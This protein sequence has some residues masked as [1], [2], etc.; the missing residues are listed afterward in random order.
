[1]NSEPRKQPKVFN[2]ANIAFVLVVCASYTSV[3]AALIY[4]RRSL[5]AWEVGVFVAAVQTQYLSSLTGQ[6]YAIRPSSA[7][8]SR[9]A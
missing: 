8:D 7:L 4:S 6:I 5:P 9:C 1:M 2:S 3:A